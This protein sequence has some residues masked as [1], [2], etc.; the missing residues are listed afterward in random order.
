MPSRSV[1]TACDQ[2][3]RQ[4]PEQV[5]SSVGGWTHFYDVPLGLVRALDQSGNTTLSKVGGQLLGSSSSSDAASFNK[6]VEQGKSLCRSLV[7]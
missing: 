4:S 7:Q 6:A 2:L 5:T 1:V 3:G